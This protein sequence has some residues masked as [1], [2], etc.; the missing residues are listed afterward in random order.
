LAADI[1]AVWGAET[2]TPADRQRITRLL[3]ER[4]AVT[5]D[6]ASERVDAQLHGSVD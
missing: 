6:R 3:L 4:V 2:T 5:V 1:P